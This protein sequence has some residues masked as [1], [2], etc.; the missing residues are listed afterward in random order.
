MTVANVLVNSTIVSGLNKSD[1]TW[2]CHRTREPIP[3]NNANGT[4]KIV[5]M[6]LKKGSPIEILPKPISLC[7]RG[8]S[9]P[10]NTTINAAINKM[11]LIFNIISKY[12]SHQ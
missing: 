10:N 11:L 12:I 8:N 1:N 4:I 3:K 6:R 5:N 2:R 7:T 9:V